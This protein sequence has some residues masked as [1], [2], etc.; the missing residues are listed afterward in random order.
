MEGAAWGG[1]FGQGDV[2]G[3][4]ALGAQ[5]R[6]PLPARPPLRGVRGEGKPAAAAERGGGSEQLCAGRC[7]PGSIPPPGHPLQRVFS[8][9]PCNCD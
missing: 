3:A 5:R 1:A 2:L 6:P 7:L 8:R 9:C 4:M